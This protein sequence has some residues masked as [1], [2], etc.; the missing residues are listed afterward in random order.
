MSDRDPLLVT[1]ATGFIGSHLVPLLCSSGLRVRC[2]VR[3]PADAA[4]LARLGVE[5][6]LGDLLDPEASQRAVAGVGSVIH[7]AHASDESAARATACLAAA[8]GAAG[9]RRFVHVSSTAVH[10]LAPRAEDGD[11]GTA[12]IP[13]SGDPY[14]RAKAEEELCVREAAPAGGFELVVLRPAIVYGPRSPFVAQVRHDAAAGRLTL[15]D[16]GRGTCN[17]VYVGDVCTAILQA[18]AAP[19]GRV[20]GKAFFIT[21]DTPVTWADFVLAFAQGVVPRPEV[22]DISV[23]R[24]RAEAARW[25]AWR[26][27]PRAVRMLRRLWERLTPGIRRPLPMSEGRV[28]RETVAVA[29]SNRLAREE[30]GWRPGTPFAEG[31]ARTLEWLSTTA[32]PP[33]AA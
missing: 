10:G 20:N 27:A 16:G 15:I 6:V 21:G 26:R 13:P 18:L 3:R 7:L 1:G 14:C 8:A 11:E 30:L 31:V 24:A 29:F 4:R 22:R 28:A 2:L 32:R 33:G 12:M 23:E 5:T 19:E 25:G 17:A 9:I